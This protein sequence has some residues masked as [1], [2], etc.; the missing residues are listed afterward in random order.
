MLIA[1]NT[2]NNGQNKSFTYNLLN[3]PKVSTVPTGTATYT[4]D[5]TGNKLRKV[6]VISGV[7][8]N[9][10][11]IGGIQYNG[12]STAD[13]LNFIQ[14]EEGRAVKQGN[15]INYEY[16][17]Y[18]GD[19]LGNTRI[20]FGTKYGIATVLQQD[21]YYPFGLEINRGITSPKNE[22]LYN[23]KELQEEFTEY[24]YGARYYDPV[25]GRWNTIDPLAET[26]RRW[27]TY[28][29]VFDNPIR[30]I[31]PDGMSPD[32]YYGTNGKY[33]GV[34]EN[35]DNGQVKIVGDENQAVLK[36]GTTINSKNVTSLATVSKTDLKE[37]LNVI[38]RTDAKTDKDQTG[39][40][41]GESSLVMKSG[42]VIQGQS[43]DKATINSIGNLESDESL[44]AIPA[45]NTQADVDATIHAHVDAT[46]VVGDK[47]Y[48]GNAL[49][50][51]I[52][53]KQDL[54]ESGTNIITGPLGPSSGFK[55]KD[56][57][58][59]IPK[60]PSI[61]IAIFQGSLAKP[62]A[63]LTVKAIDRILSKP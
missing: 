61:G 18:L 5:A 34:D 63:T 42:A 41:H 3:L 57:D 36:T 15:G 23:K 60:Q 13:T 22:Y 38:K 26:S 33:L 39:G 51:S 8:T 28:N 45:G 46:E 43:G 59:V 21:D 19:N 10:D 37:S 4:Y 6:S 30:L 40:L 25:I 55:P 9:T 49:E 11:Y 32:Q 44:P 16:V 48:F 17:Y 24:D 20:T 54:N 12:A 14:T 50:P 2:A 53:D 56:L 29:Y 31:D 7:T 58:H 62:A 27:S 1:S 35:G 47:I 52:L